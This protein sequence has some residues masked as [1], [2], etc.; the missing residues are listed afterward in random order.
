MQAAELADKA[1]GFLAGINRFDDRLR[2]RQ[3]SISRD[4]GRYRNIFRMNGP[5]LAGAYWF[6]R[7]DGEVFHVGKAEASL[8][9]RITHHPG[10]AE[11]RGAAT[12]G[13]EG[14]TGEGWGFP[15]YKKLNRPR[16]TAATRQSILDGDFKVGWGRCRAMDGGPTAG[17]LSASAVLRR[18]P[19]LA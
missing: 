3:A 10:L 5:T 2:A 8:R 4:G 14:T 15:N 11:W 1:E 6:Y 19:Q 18:R 16:V 7:P 17:G 12:S 13:Y 9:A